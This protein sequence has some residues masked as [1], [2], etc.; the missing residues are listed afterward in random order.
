VTGP[1]N[2]LP[3]RRGSPHRREPGFY[4]WQQRHA[5]R[6]PPKWWP[7][8][9]PW[10]PAGEFP[11]QRM[12]RRFFIRFAIGV[13][14]I[15]AFV[16]AGPLIVIAQLLAAFGL[17]SPGSG[18]LA[19]VVLVA[20]LAVLF[21]GARGARRIA[22]P[23]ADLIEAAG[24]LKRAITRPG[25]PRVTSARGSCGRSCRHSMPWPLDSKRTSSSVVRC[26]PT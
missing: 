3:P 17:P 10:P 7:H 11:W 15:F 9:E 18:I 20:L 25:S 2:G 13:F 19:A 5:H 16:V 24:R 6:E 8:D 14:L 21:G 1:E 4:R 12:R 23:F 22:L 26:L